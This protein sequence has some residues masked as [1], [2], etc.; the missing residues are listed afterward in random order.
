MAKFQAARHRNAFLFPKMPR[1]DAGAGA[2]DVIGTPFI[3]ISDTPLKLEQDS[4]N[5]QL[6]DD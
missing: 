5:T 4:I 1:R 6:V 2:H 3:A